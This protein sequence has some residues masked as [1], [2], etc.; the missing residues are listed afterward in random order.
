LVPQTHEH[1]CD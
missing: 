1:I